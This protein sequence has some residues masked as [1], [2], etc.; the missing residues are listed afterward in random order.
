MARAD[1][2]TLGLLN[3]YPG[4]MW[5]D[6]WRY[7]QIVGAGSRLMPGCQNAPYL[8]YER[9]YIADALL[10]ALGK[11]AQY[12]G[13]Y[14]A[15]IWVTDEAVTVNSDL[16]WSS[17][18]LQTRFGYVS[19]FG[20]RAVTQIAANVLVTYSDTDG[21]Q[22]NDRATL[23]V[24]GVTNIPADEIRVFF[25]TADGAAN[26]ADEYWEIEPLSVVKSGDNATIS[27]GRWLFVHPTRVWA[28]EYEG[29]T[30]HKF[31]GSTTSADDFVNQVDVYRVY[32]DATSAVQ[33]LLDPADVGTENTVVNATASVQNEQQGH[34]RIYTG[35][36]QTAPAAQPRTVRVS[37]RAGYPLVNGQM[38]R[39]LA[40]ACIRYANTLMPQQPQMC[41]R[42]L[43]MWT[44]D[45]AVSQNLAARD[46][47]TPP[48]LGITNGGLFA[49]GVI[50]ARR[51]PLLARPSKRE[52]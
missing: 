14:P 23:T 21:D 30:A 42:S 37:Y 26:A 31:A 36:S 24:S 38:D 18:T 19:A 3:L 52:A 1:A 27:G 51:N 45:R 49:W 41:D 43:S 40:Q 7:N 4:Y 13:Y 16:S 8:Q 9:Q 46:A 11:A 34:F 33:L 12:L 2:R 48:P 47:W 39:Q 32:A 6:N 25:R 20:K 35:S 15:P 10:E 17:Q 28:K 5:E 50:A 29:D 22:I 44:D